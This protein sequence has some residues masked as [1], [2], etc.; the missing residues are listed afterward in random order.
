V[1]IFA[2]CREN[3]R[4]VEGYPKDF[5]PEQPNEMMKTFSN[6]LKAKMTQAEKDLEDEE[7]KA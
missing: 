1:A 5:K 2:S 7:L 6:G 3:F 4:H